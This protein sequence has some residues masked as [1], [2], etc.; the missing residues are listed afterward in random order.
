MAKSKLDPFK[1]VTFSVP[2]GE[3][4]LRHVHR[5]RAAAPPLAFVAFRMNNAYQFFHGDATAAAVTLPDGSL[6]V[7][8]TDLP[9]H[10]PPPTS[11]HSGD[12]SESARLFA[13]LK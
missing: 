7:E 3:E 12:K 8:W 2:S 10:T 13:Q 4:S 5:A 9:G 6:F 1:G 11:P